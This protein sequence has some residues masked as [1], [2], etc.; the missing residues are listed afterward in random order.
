VCGA[1]PS[2]P[3]SHGVVLGHGD[4][5]NF[6]HFYCTLTHSCSVS[7]VSYASQNGAPRRGVRGR[8]EPGV[9][10]TLRSQS[11]HG[12]L[13][14]R[15]LDSGLLQYQVG[16]CVTERNAAVRPSDLS[17]GGSDRRLN[18]HNSYFPS[19]IIKIIKLRK[20]G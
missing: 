12:A 5:Y 15:L 6:H 3:V 1:L 8:L 13:T 7:L 2:R 11:R 14:G 10:S 18:L 19:N 17:T 9:A 16:E 4:N 20:I